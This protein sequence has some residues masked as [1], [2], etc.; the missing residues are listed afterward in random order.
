MS[1]KVLNI[2]LIFVII[3]GVALRYLSYEHYEPEHG[4]VLQMVM[5]QGYQEYGEFMMDL[6]YIFDDKIESPEPS[7]HFPPLYPLLMAYTLDLKGHEHGNEFNTGFES[8]KKM[9]FV[10]AIFTLVIIYLL[11]RF[12]FGHIKGLFCASVFSMGGVFIDNSAKCLGENLQVILL[13]LFIFM[14]IL[15]I[16]RPWLLTI[17]GFVL[18]LAYLSKSTLP[19][20]GTA[21]LILIGAVFLVL[22]D[23]RFML[24][25]IA[26]YAIFLRTI[27]PWGYR[28]FIYLS[29]FE[30]SSNINSSIGLALN[31]PLL[32][33]KGL[34]LNIFPVAVIPLILVII[35][36]VDLKRITIKV[37][38]DFLLLILSFGSLI[39]AL[40][41][42]SSFYVKEGF[43]LP[44]NTI[45]YS[46]LSVVPLM[47][48][49]LRHMNI[50]TTNCLRRIFICAVIFL[51]SG[52]GTYSWA[53]YE[54]DKPL[55]N[56]A[57][58][59]MAGFIGQLVD[60]PPLYFSKSINKNDFYYYTV[61]MKYPAV[62]Y[63]TDK[64]IGN[65]RIVKQYNEKLPG[66]E[67]I[68]AVDPAGHP[69]DPL[70]DKVQRILLKRKSER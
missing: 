48:L 20:W 29:T 3:S 11:T 52:I 57:D 44:Y 26:A 10:L 1:I 14:F 4:A 16:R 61:Y 69:C 24:P 45:R 60:I 49:I 27:L 51:I 53:V 9:S 70:S 7:D 33:T 17:A 65:Y 54:D 64:E 22:N 35:F 41:Y 68:F 59:A 28:N 55:I 8:L 66:W 19:F 30:T 67:P 25:S 15:S 46:I 5:A 62:D 37:K 34:A 18:G 40:I 58:I 36:F 47:W 63:I 21:G 13:L 23:R 6:G 31:N 50:N 12:L 2:F 42:S 56:E 38:I 32:F 39:I 43:Y